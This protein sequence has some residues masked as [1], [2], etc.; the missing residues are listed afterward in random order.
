MK[1]PRERASAL[2]ALL[3]D[4][5]IPKTWKVISSPPGVVITVMFRAAAP[6]TGGLS[7]SPLEEC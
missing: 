1:K 7:L 2:R 4:T 6:R 5:E 3:S